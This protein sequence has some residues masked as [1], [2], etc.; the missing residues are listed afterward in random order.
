MSDYI[1]PSWQLPLPAG[2]GKLTWN[3]GPPP[4]GGPGSLLLSRTQGA[5]VWTA[6]AL[7]DGRYYPT[8]G[9]ADAEW[10]LHP[11]FSPDELEGNPLRRMQ[12][13]YRSEAA[14][15]CSWN[16][17]VH[18]YTPGITTT[19]WQVVSLTR[20]TALLVDRHGNT[21]RVFVNAKRRWYET[22]KSESL[23]S[24]L[25]RQQWRA[26]RLTDERRRVQSII[27]SVK[28]QIETFEQREGAHD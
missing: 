18:D 3:A 23:W 26:D 28:Y 2:V 7:E 1:C 8:H 13:V 5:G 22:S 9:A 27:G 4:L 17:L 6:E 14:M 10:A 19:T 11:G 15:T 25:H 21:K 24:L 20:R 16:G 12:L